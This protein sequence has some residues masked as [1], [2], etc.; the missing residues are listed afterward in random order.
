[1]IYIKLILPVIQYIPFV[2]YWFTSFKESIPY[3]QAPQKHHSLKEFCQLLKHI[4]KHINHIH[5]QPG[6]ENLNIKLYKILVLMF[7]WLMCFYNL[8]LPSEWMAFFRNLKMR[9][10][11][12]ETSSLDK[13]LNDLKKII[14][15]L[16]VRKWKVNKL[17]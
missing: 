3:P 16:L 4:S 9:N 7:L 11:F 6:N 10:I 17:T 13:K 12:L 15:F 5:T 1:M 8:Y 2:F 14:H